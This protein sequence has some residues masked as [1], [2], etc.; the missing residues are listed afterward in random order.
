MAFVTQLA[1]LFLCLSKAILSQSEPNQ[2]AISCAHVL[3]LAPASLQQNDPFC[4]PL[5]CKCLTPG[6]G[7]HFCVYIF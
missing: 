7:E 2:R 1:V 3:S 4:V 6:G 5:V